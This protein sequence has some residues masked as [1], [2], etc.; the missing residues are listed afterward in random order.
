MS[1]SFDSGLKGLIVLSAG[2]TG[3][4]LFPAQALAEELVR[5]GYVIHLLTD[6]RVEDFGNRFP[7]TQVHIIRSATLTPGKPMKL[8][9]QLLRLLSGVR[10]ARSILG[11]LHPVAVVG[12][13]GYPSFPPLLA[14]MSRRIDTFIHEQNAVIGRANKVLAYGVTSIASS[15]PKIAGLTPRAAEKVSFVDRKSVV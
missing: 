5:R 3:G 7:A 9:G 6:D 1:M 4:H 12:F 8:P 15:F 14:A 2:G 13:G 10:E 11:H